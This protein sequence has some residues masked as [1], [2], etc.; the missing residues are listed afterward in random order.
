MTIYSL[1]N[2]KGFLEPVSLEVKNP[3]CGGIKVVF[4]GLY[5]LLCPHTVQ[6]LFILST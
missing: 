5:F 1:M 2:L 3:D 4:I 6:H